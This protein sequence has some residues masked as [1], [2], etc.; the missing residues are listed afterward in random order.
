VGTPFV[1]TQDNNP[2]TVAGCVVGKDKNKFSCKS[3]G[4]KNVVC[5]D[6]NP[7]TIMDRC[8][9]KGQNSKT[10]A[11]LGSLKDCDDDNACT[12]DACKNGKCENTALKA[13]C[14]D[15]NPCTEG[16][17]CKAGKCASGAK[18]NCEDGNLCTDDSCSSKAG[19]CGHKSN[20]KKCNDGD[21]CASNDA[22][23]GSACKSAK[24]ICD[25]S[26]PCTTDAC[27]PGV[28][29]VA[30]AVKN[31]TTCAG[32]GQCWGGSCLVAK[33][34]NTVC[35]FNEDT[36]SC[37]ADCP[38]GGGLCKVG[39]ATCTAKCRTDRC[40]ATVKAC[41]D[42]KIVGKKLTCPKLLT[43]L[44]LTKNAAKKLASCV[45]KASPA[46]VTAHYALG[47][48]L[49]TKCEGNEWSGKPCKGGGLIYTNC[50]AACQSGVC[51]GEDLACSA[52]GGEKGCAA[53]ATCVDKCPNND[54]TCPPKCIKKGTPE[55]S[56]L[57]D[58][59]TVCVTAKCL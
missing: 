35:E 2:C 51:A 11:C 5:D 46:A 38:A 7:C 9:A 18:K 44:S 53:I 10:Y 4:A 39:D 54:N 24:T 3:E 6:N 29:C 25:D 32:G 14:S 56:S 23:A 12:A 8:K 41:D 20:T 55:A 34:G 26:N 59:L 42:D 58:K 50:I 47:Y 33:C 48:C 15:D 57:Y 37:S 52:S 27:A 17:A 30:S 36:K 49:A 1:C 21:V 16:D 28:G 40:A 31:G 22:C 13:S 19:G 45:Q 43:C